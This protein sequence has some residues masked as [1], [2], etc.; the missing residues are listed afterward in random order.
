MHIDKNDLIEFDN[1]TMNEQELI[2]FLSHLNH[3]DSCLDQMIEQ[4]N[5]SPVTAPS[6]L[7]KQIMDKAI[8]SEVQFARAA[9]KVSRKVQFLRY[10]LQTA[11]GVAAALLLLFSIPDIDFSELKSNYSSVQSERTVP[12]HNSQLYD[13]SRGINQSICDGTSSLVQY[14]SDFSSKIMNGGK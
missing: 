11:A 2:E 3:C 4:E 10:G 14:I 12:E 8:S 9:N 5:H 7:A 1:G 6:Y 13:F